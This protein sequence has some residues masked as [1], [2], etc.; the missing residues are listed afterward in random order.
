MVKMQGN[1]LSTSKDMA[2]LQ[3]QLNQ[4]SDFELT[5]DSVA[6]DSKTAV[7]DLCLDSRQVKS[8]DVF[9]ALSG[10]NV[11][12]LDYAYQAERA[13]A[14]AVIAEPTKAQRAGFVRRQKP[15]KIPVIEC[16]DLSEVLGDLA[17]AFY[18][19]PSQK[20]QVTAITGTNGKTSTA[21]LMMHALE[22]L[23]IKAGYIGTLGVGGIDQLTQIQNT[24]PSAIAIQ[25]NMA[26]MLA[27]G[28]Q[29]VCI[30]VSSHALD[31]NR[32]NG[33]RVKTAVFTNLS[34]DHLDYHQTM[35]AYAAA[36]LKLFTHFK[37]DVSIINIDDSVG[38]KW[39][40]SELSQQQTLSYA[41]KNVN[42]EFKAENIELLSAG[43]AFELSTQQQ[44]LAIETSLLGGF[45][46]LNTL[47]V[48]AALDWAGHSGKEIS[49]V[50]NKLQPVPGRMNRIDDELNGVIVVVDYAHTPDALLQVLK[51]LRDHTS[52]KLWCVF[53]CGGNRDKG[54]R[55][56]MGE[57]AEQYADHVVLTDDN[58]RFESPAQIIADIETGM[59]QKP[60]VI[61]NRKQAMAY[62]LDHSQRGDIILIAGKGHESTQE[63]S[64][65]LLPF[66]DI[67]T[68]K[69][70][71]QVAV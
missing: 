21:W 50:I 15:L 49:Q 3:R 31:Q 38:A 59:T 41:I 67:E 58:P 63:V 2:W 29:H 66:N 70:L 18:D 52:G 12:G 13:G 28:C 24:T 14:V 34:R 7:N 65:K 19:K 22:Q 26:K 57:I 30:E 71:L 9:I 43:I 47:A 32:F 23:G 36:K 33:T 16:R 5:A 62:V 45:N 60:H 35:D 69:E 46:V 55:A 39:L 40:K 10:F 1:Y 68:A 8:G 61:N 53:G 64:G 37:P 44:N 48:I 4:L 51:A 20:M 6:L 27:A 25:K 54:K 56:M 17:S 11:H 42:A